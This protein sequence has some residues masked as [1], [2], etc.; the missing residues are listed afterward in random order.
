MKFQDDGNYVMWSGNLD[1]NLIIDAGDRSE[2]WNTRNAVGY[3]IEDTNLDGV[4]DATE[5]TITW[6]HRNKSGIQLNN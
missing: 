2:A 5:R 6:N 4:V 1:T 3:R